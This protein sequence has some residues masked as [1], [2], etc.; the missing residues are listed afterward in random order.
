MKRKRIEDLIKY[1]DSKDECSYCIHEELC[2]K[3]E[4]RI[5]DSALGLLISR[6]PAYWNNRAINEILDLINKG[7][8][9]AK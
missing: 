8:K 4:E 7:N 5:S 3:L 6:V 1:C 2:D 9:D